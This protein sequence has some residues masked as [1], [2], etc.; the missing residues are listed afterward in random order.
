MRKIMK[1]TGA[2]VS[3]ALGYAALQVTGV[4]P[5]T[6]MGIV[7]LL[8]GPAVLIACVGTYRH[9]LLANRTR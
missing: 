3:A 7:P 4:T 9:G 2:L 1:A 6:E 5:S 8:L